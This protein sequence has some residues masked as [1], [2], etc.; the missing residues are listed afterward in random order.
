VREFSEGGE[1]DFDAG[2][3][4]G[5]E[6]AVDDELRFVCEEGERELSPAEAVERQRSPC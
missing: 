3:L 4:R 1:P 2:E 6:V 5:V